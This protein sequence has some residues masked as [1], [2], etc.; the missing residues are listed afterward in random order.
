MTEST[1]TPAMD[2]EAPR[3]RSISVSFM[4]RRNGGGDVLVYLLNVHVR[5]RPMVVDQVLR[6]ANLLAL[7]LAPQLEAQLAAP[8]AVLAGDM[9]WIY[10]IRCSVCS[11]ARM[12]SSKSGSSSTLSPRARADTLQAGA[13]LLLLQVR[14]K[15]LEP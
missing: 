11:T 2:Q 10:T 15:L 1:E 8:Y 14:R 12:T 13:M 7:Q 5:P 3:R 6:L 9:W 4:A